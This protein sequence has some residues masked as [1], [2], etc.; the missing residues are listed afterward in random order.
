[1]RKNSFK[2]LTGESQKM[3]NPKR[4]EVWMV[5]LG[6][7]AKVRPCLVISIPFED[8]DRALVTIL[9]HATSARSS[10]FEVK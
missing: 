3:T 1:M 10:R 8:R 7:A 6:F 4:G 9:P 5:D 2:S